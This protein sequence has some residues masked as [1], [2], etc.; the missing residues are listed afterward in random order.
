MNKTEAAQVLSNSLAVAARN[1]DRT[2]DKD[3]TECFISEGWAGYLFNGK[4]S[5]KIT[6]GT[7]IERAFATRPATSEVL[8]LARKAL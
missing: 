6:E 8:R 1:S 5:V 2:L 4:G 7:V 3:F